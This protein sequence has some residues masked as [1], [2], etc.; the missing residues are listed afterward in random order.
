MLCGHWARYRFGI[1]GRFILS[2][3]YLSYGSKTLSTFEALWT[4]CYEEPVRMFFANLWLFEDGEDLESLVLW[5]RI[6]INEDLFNDMFS[7]E[8]SRERWLWGSLEAAKPAIAEENS[9]LYD[10]GPLSRCFENRILAHIIIT[11]LMPR[12]ESLNNISN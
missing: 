10:F 5:T 7:F 1:V 12:K 8:F 11:T 4:K 2:Y 3:Q 9:D 6:V